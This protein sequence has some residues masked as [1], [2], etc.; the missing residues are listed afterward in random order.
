V[1]AIR[2]IDAHE[3]RLK[4]VGSMGD[5]TRSWRARTATGALLA[6]GALFV[7]GVAL[8]LAAALRFGAALQRSAASCGLATGHG[9]ACSAVIANAAGIIVAAAAIAAELHWRR[10]S[11]PVVVVLGA[12]AAGAG[13]FGAALDLFIVH[14][15]GTCA[16][17]FS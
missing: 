8:G 7:L 17:L 9:M 13:V 12:V 14:E 10:P 5:S 11:R 3:Q 1:A 2:S 16:A 15:I 4:A 6:G